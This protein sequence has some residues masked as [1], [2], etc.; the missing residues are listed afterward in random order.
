M[1]TGAI[2]AEGQ[3]L[4]LDV[5]AQ[6]IGKVPVDVAALDDF[7]NRDAN[8]GSVVVLVSRGL[9]ALGDTV[10]ASRSRTSGLAMTWSAC[11]GATLYR[12]YRRSSP[13]ALESVVAETPSTSWS[14]ADTV[15][16]YFQVRPVDA[17]GGERAD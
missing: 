8:P 6:A 12:V 17:C 5:I 16:G 3:V 7:G 9:V 10:R 2:T 15:T 1:A 14:D 4:T 13:T 11:E